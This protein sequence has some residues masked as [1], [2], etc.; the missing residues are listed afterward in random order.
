MF[1]QILNRQ[2]L[3]CVAIERICASGKPVAIY[4]AGYSGQEC[5]EALKR[6]GVK[7]VCDDD[8]EKIGKLFN[9]IPIV[10]VAHL[11]KNE[12]YFIIIT[13]GYIAGMRRRL[14]QLGLS[15]KLLDIDFGRF[16]RANENYAYYVQNRDKI[17]AVYALLEDGVSKEVFL[18]MINYRIHRDRKEILNIVETG[19]YFDTKIIQFSNEEVFAD[20]GACDGDTIRLFCERV[21]NKYKGVVA[22]EPSLRNYV[23]LTEFTKK[24]H[25]V[26]CFNVAAWSE[27]T[28]L[29]FEMPDSKNS[30]VSHDGGCDVMA[31]KLDDFMAEKGVIPTFIKA[32][33][34]G[35]EQDAIRGMR[36]IISTYRPKLA[37]CVYHKIEDMFEI[38]LLVNS[39]SD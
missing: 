17:E 23:R 27:N 8:P 25:D 10:S 18:K 30:Y 3:V 38:P 35:A 39:I 20:L 9:G 14:E 21:D 6:R 1:E 12:D 11:P 24:M 29:K 34:E 36:H 15:D 4:G 32:D 7:Y 37:L 22:M 13:N 2:N 5:F 26:Q 31:V 33:I 19:Q 28:M 16:D